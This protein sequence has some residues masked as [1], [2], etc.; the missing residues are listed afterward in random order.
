VLAMAV[1]LL[2]T[3]LLACVVGAT[4]TTDALGTALQAILAAAAFQL[5][6]SLFSL[7]TNAIA[8]IDGGSIVVMGAL[9][10]A[11]QGLL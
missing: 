5:G 2:A 6:R 3:F 8:L 4:A 10:I 9:M 11:A 7:K 1:Q